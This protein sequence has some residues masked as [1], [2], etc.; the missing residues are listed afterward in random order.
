[1]N[2]VSETVVYSNSPYL[3][4]YLGC[5]IIKLV[6]VIS[7]QFIYISISNGIHGMLRNLLYYNNTHY[8]PIQIVFIIVD[9]VKVCHDHRSCFLFKKMV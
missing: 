5:L 8:D 3:A 6:V 7:M 4:L 1:M 9:F 2:R